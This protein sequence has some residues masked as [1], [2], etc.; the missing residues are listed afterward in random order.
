MLITYP[1]SLIYRNS[2]ILIVTQATRQELLNALVLT[3][4]CIYTPSV[5][6]NQ[7][8]L[9]KI[10][11]TKPSKLSPPLT[12]NNHIKRETSTDFLQFFIN[13]QILISFIPWVLICHVNNFRDLYRMYL[14]GVHIY[15]VTSG[16]YIVYKSLYVL[17]TIKTLK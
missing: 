5:K 6:F 8:F 14:M 1:Y 11:F 3:K 16:L 4:S 17:K 15:Y 10:V 13:I 12:A 9:G 7:Y 2:C